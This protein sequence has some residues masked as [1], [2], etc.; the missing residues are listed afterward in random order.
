M[1]IESLNEK[2]VNFFKTITEDQKNSTFLLSS[3]LCFLANSVR[4]VANVV[5]TLLS[6]VLLIFC[7]PF[8]SPR[9]ELTARCKAGGLNAGFAAMQIFYS[10]FNLVSVG[11]LARLTPTIEEKVG[12]DPVVSAF[13]AADL[14][15]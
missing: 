11:V 1:C 15:P 6:S 13:T 2:N 4:L 12:V 14:D 10:L 3:P 9:E 5:L 8:K 7:C